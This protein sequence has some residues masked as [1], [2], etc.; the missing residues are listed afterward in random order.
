MKKLE[1]KRKSNIEKLLTGLRKRKI[2]KES[3][4]NGSSNNNFQPGHTNPF[5][6]LNPSPN[7]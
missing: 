3:N 1:G 4:P 5:D 6:I 7:V 2:E